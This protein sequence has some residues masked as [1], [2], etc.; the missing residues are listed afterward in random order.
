[1]LCKVPLCILKNPP[2]YEPGTGLVYGVGV[3]IIV[4]NFQLVITALVTSAILYIVSVSQTDREIERQRDRETENR[5]Q[6]MSQI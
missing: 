1:M 5:D 6:R 4:I 3:A 2:R